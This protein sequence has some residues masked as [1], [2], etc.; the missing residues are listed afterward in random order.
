MKSFIINISN[1]E[2]FIRESMFLYIDSDLYQQD[3]N[4]KSHIGIYSS[5]K[6]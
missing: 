1:E 5:Q 3:S 2:T 6:S 4:S